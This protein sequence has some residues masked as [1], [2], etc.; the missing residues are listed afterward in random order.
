MYLRWRAFVVASIALVLL[1]MAPDSL[2][3]TQAQGS[4]TCE[5][6]VLAAYDTLATTCA[7]LVRNETCVAG[8]P[9]T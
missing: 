8:T 1:V 2:T 5:A 3:S 6:L 7:G 9:A 4:D